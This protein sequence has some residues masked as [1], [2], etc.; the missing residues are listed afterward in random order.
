MSII[1]LSET[2]TGP[3]SNEQFLQSDAKRQFGALL[4]NILSSIDKG[5][6]RQN[7]RNEQGNYHSFDHVHNT[8]L[9][10]G[11]RGMGKTSFIFSVIENRTN[12][13]DEW[14]KDVCVLGVIDPTMIETKEHIFLNVIQTI[15]EKVELSKECS[16]VQVFESNYK[17]WLDSL[18][19]LAGGLSIL[20]GVGTEELKRDLW[21]SPE[22]ILERGLVNAKQGKKL[23][24]Y[25]HAF[26]DE[27]LKILKKKAFLLIL[28]DIDTSLNQGKSILETLRKYFTSRKLIVT[29]LGDI[30]LYSTIV[31]QLQWEKI[32]PEGVLR[33]YEDIKDY[34][35]QVLHLE[36]QYL[37]KLLKPEN[38]ITLRQLFELKDEIEVQVS[39]DSEKRSLEIFIKELA[40]ECFRVKNQPYNA[41]LF[42]RTLLTQSTRSVI[43]VLKAWGA[44]GENISSDN[45]SMFA[46]S[47][48]Q[49]FYTTIKKQ[50]EQHNLVE[51]HDS[52]KL[53]NLI[54]KYL[55]K[56]RKLSDNDLKLLPAQ[57]SDDENVSLVYLNALINSRLA[58]K[59]YLSYFLRVGYVLTQFPQIKD[60]SLSKFIEHIGMNAEITNTELARRLLT[61]FTINSNTH[62]NRP[63]F[64]GNLSLSKEYLSKIK[65]REKYAPYFT[66]VHNPRGGQHAFLSFFTMI[67][68]LADASV[69]KDSSEFMRLQGALREYSVFDSQTSSLA[70]DSVNKEGY[71][72]TEELCEK[73]V[74]WG[75]DSRN[76]TQQLSIA[77]LASIWLTIESSFNEIDKRSENKSKNYLHLH[78][79]YLA[80]FLNAM[81]VQCEQK[82][83]KTVD[84]RNPST[85]PNFFYDKVKGYEPTET[86]TFFD[87]LYHCPLLYTTEVRE[88]LIESKEFVPQKAS[89]K[90]PR[91]T[92]YP[93]G[94]DFK[95][96]SE[97]EQ[98]EAIRA[99]E[100]WTKNGDGAIGSKL[101]KAGYKNVPAS[102]GPVL[103]K[104]KTS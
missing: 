97:E 11:K 49:I 1:N 14:H 78:E 60:G 33:R 40:E 86:Y 98:I 54:A 73:L 89:S 58:P 37:T 46:E 24:R 103:R 65:A 68:M 17:C 64:F 22:L 47:L 92:K 45:L 44:K 3:F 57:F 83:G 71:E 56:E 82:K 91:K 96:L 48:Q 6:E 50:F 12:D 61:T 77:D 2:D 26:L 30:D 93:E 94:K 66:L 35:E 100:G 62:T 76:I 10:N 51:P 32:D 38:R 18:K 95:G 84:I 74:S 88:N 20:D 55:L 99:I 59:D 104:L 34:R 36:E 25:F 63:F 19:T 21:D 80:A 70:E 67:G 31:R 27:S 102:L 39:G 85:D 42:E 16:S 53:L 72:L 43:Q 4:K 28:D 13:E 23:E 7:H 87:F 9:I 79:L 8:V 81:F 41:R 5:N 29:L 101:R 90:R 15:H 75:R 52:G 69:V